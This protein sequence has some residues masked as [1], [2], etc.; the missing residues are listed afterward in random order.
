MKVLIVGATGFIGSRL[1]RALLAAGHEVTG[2]SRGAEGLP[3]G[4]IHARF[5]FTRLPSPPELRRL[6]SHQDVVINAVG[7]LR[8]RGAQTFEQLH[9]VGPRALFAACA[10]SGVRRV[11]QIS[12]L[13]AAAEAI[14]TYHRSKF[15]ADRFL[16]EQAL[17]WVIV[18]PSLVYGAGG[19][20]TRLFE[21]LASMPV[22]P[23]PGGG[24]QRVQPVHVDDLVAALVRLVEDPT[25]QRRIIE[26]AGPTQMSMRDYLVGLR[27]VLG[28]P[29]TL[30]ISVPRG[31]MRIAARV[32]DYLPGAMLDSETFGMLERG[33]VTSPT[34]FAQV[35]GRSPRPVEQFVARAERV[36]RWDAAS[37]DWLLP[38][39]R[40]AVAAMWFIAAIVSL[41]PYPVEE[42]LQLLR[43]IGL[44]PALAP[45]AL[46]TAIGIDFLF[47]VL[48]LLP[49]R[50]RWLW[51]AQILVVVAY[52][53]IIS[54]RLPALWLEP[55]GPVAKNL[56]ILALLLLLWQLERRK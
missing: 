56:P 46:T 37:L 44:S 48:T 19:N 52:T 7:I 28:G 55:F 10:A 36:E 50:W 23:L 31:L 51:A 22:I 25:P 5:D 54:W 43:D 18:R 8:S 47:G 29:R 13:G 26:V 32:G 4:V 20:S 27:R 9:D 35:L 34:T 1:A 49:R 41:G 38:L 30:T 12:A 16:K 33:A 6:V 42:S 3:H 45:V 21:K 40:I 15:A 14:A 17:D 53:I 2:A 11:V 24:A 39:L